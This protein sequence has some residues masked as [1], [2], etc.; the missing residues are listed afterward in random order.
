MMVAAV[1]LAASATLAQQAPEASSE[2][3]RIVVVHVITES[4][5]LLET[6]PPRI[7]A[8]PDAPYS[9]EAIRESLRQLFRSGRYA[10]VRAEAT[11][12]PGGVRL[13]FIVRRNFYIDMVHVVGLE[14][15]PGESTAL[16]ALR[17]GLGQA[18]RETVMT[19]AIARLQEV[20]AEEGFYEARVGYELSPVPGTQQMNITVQ[21]TPG[22]RAAIGKMSVVNRTAFG[23]AELL[24]RSKLREGQRIRTR[25]L[26]V[27]GDRLRKF[28]VKKGYLGAR[29]TTRR[30]DYDPQTHTVPIE[31][32]V[33][34]GAHV[35]AEVNGV[36]ISDRDLRKLLP[37]FQEG[38]VDEDL[39]QEGRRNIR[40]YLE[41]RGY[42][43]A[44]VQYA[45]GEDVEK[46]QQVITY[47][48]E[49]GNQRRLAGV[50]FEGNRYFSGQLLRGRLAILPARFPASGRFSRRMLRD[51]EESI[52]ELYIANGFREVKVTSQVV[53]DYAGREGD[54]FVRFQIE[55]GPQT[56]VAELR[57]EGAQ[58]FTEDYLLGQAIDSEPGQPFSE[59]NVTSDR[60]NILAL[61]FNEGF[62][63]AR[64]EW[65]A[66]DTG[67]PNRVRL[68]YRITEG[69]QIRV[70]Q[71]LL[72][73]Y[74]FTKPG[75]IMDEV[76]IEP[77]QPLREGEVIETQ[78]RLYNLG[79]FSRV[80]IA[81][82]NPEGTDTE[83]TL[84]VQVEEARRYTLAYGGGIEVQR[85]GSGGD[86]VSGQVRASPRG[87]FE[88]TRANFLGRAHTVAFK[89][90]FSTLQSRALLSYTAPNL[91]TR[92][93]S[94]ALL[95]T[96]LADRTRDVRTF[97]STRYEATAQLEQRP[98]PFSSL[99]YRYTFRRVLVDP[100]SLKVDPNQIPL[101]SQPTKISALGFT[102]IRERRDNP[103]DASRG[104][105]NT[106]DISVAAR[107]LGSSA[108]FTRFFAQNSSFHPLGRGLVFA[109]S[110]R[111]GI[112]EPIGDTVPTDIP[113]PERFFAG[114]GN[115]LRGLG[116]NQAGPRD[117][118][119][120]FPIGGLAMLVFNQELRFPLRLPFVGGRVGGAIFYDAGGVFT[121]ANRIT[122]RSAPPE[123]DLS[124]PLDQQVP[125]DYFSHTIGFGF[126]YATP[127]GPVRLDLGY[128]LNPP[129]FAFCSADGTVPNTSCAMGQM[130]QTSRLPRFQF[131]FNIGSIF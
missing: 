74:E 40:D 112:E 33:S 102:W 23:E 127:I 89:T 71:V 34:A 114:G 121:R 64:F 48:V 28:L 82:Q 59:F 87:L 16:A 13:D 1:C 46:Q 65:E 130:A 39:L 8:Q 36:K 32:E 52:R 103:A 68:T 47:T 41:R 104:S 29:V 53:E 76:Q 45:I 50:S 83:K 92:P 5:E 24:R 49:R 99:L 123:P 7:P 113:L 78:R 116:L 105:F 31:M 11:D 25:R 20:L 81:P 22:R 107:G 111:I 42:F 85:L 84:V 110:S 95:L 75:V 2:N 125:L 61:Y 86:P 131:F 119:T 14:P 124:Q 122:L 126:R 27:A 94:L 73:G 66:E 51:D 35:R 30:G 38:T 6:N 62:P 44:D 37:I 56:R 63:E 117:P 97:T 77:G 12:V 18:Y 69:S 19:E 72:S 54:L 58:A 118:V 70:K 129:R 26:E 67:E 98:S 60:D 128:Q 21:V 3:R 120:G 101:F 43:D 17:L 4:G 10:D 55:E 15:P 90:R 80:A 96:G 57:V 91:L 93:T 9:S 115:S 109:R 79:V 88:V 106:V 100:D 108:S